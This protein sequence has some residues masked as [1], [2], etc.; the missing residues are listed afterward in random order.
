M[1]LVFK[2]TTVDAWRLAMTEGRYL[3]SHDDIRDGF[4]HLSAGSQLR[5]TLQKYFR[6]KRDLLLIAYDGDALGSHLKW[7]ISRNGERFP[8]YYGPLPTALRLWQRPLEAGPDGVPVI[9][10]DWLTC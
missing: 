10:D 7:E 4:I 2:V 5:G 3:G 1:S 9:E 6:D 8:H